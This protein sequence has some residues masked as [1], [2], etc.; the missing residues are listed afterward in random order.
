MEIDMTN[1]T[2]TFVVTKYKTGFYLNEMMYPSTKAAIDDI[3]LGQIDADT[4]ERVIE[5]DLTVGSSRDVTRLCAL[6][7]WQ[8]LDANNEHA[9]KEMRQWLESFSL[10][11]A[12]LT[13]DTKDIRH[14]YGL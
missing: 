8:I 11:C 6:E 2:F 5:I 13:G 4:I 3:A 10:D 12:H 1:Q 7:V 9:G 14:F